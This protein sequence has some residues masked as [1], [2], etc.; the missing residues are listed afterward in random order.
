M[1]NNSNTIIVSLIGGG[2]IGSSFGMF[3][4]F[5][6]MLVGCCVGVWAVLSE[7]RKK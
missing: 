3:G 2:F 1:M 7:E 4:A 5:A 6:G